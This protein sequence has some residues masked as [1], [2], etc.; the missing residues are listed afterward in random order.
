MV[1][2]VP[3]ARVEEVPE[4][5]GTVV[6][7]RGR[8]LALFHIGGRFYATDNECLHRGGPLGD[9]FLTGEVVT[10]PWH[11]WEYDVRT[12]RHVDD[13]SLGVA[14]FDVVVRN[15]RVWVRI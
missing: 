5:T 10:C 4:G 3:V 14:T 11:G 8:P 15:G 7:V 13:P 9:G 12:G 1:E 2:E 6:E